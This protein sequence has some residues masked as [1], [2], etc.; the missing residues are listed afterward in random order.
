MRASG[1]VEGLALDKDMV[2]LIHILIQLWDE[3]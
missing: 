2:V 1:Q 3:R